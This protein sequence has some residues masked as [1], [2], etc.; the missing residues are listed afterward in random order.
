MKDTDL[1]II[2]QI[3]PPGSHIGILGGGQL[4]RMIAAAAV[5]MG[6]HIVI[7]SD[8][9]NAPASECATHT[10]HADY[11]D[12]TALRKFA[13][14]VDVVTLEF[15]NIPLESLNILSDI[16]PTRP[17]S[18]VLGIAQY[19]VAEKTF[20]DKH[21]IPTA[22]WRQ[23]KNPAELDLVRK[24]RPE[25][26]LKMARF[27]YDG[28]GQY[29]LNQASPTP[30][31]N[32]DAIYEDIINF[33]KEISVIIARNGKGDS[34]YYPPVHN[35]HRD[36]ILSSTLAP[37]HI[38]DSAKDKA[39]KIAQNIAE[40]IH[41]HGILAV[42]MFL[43]DDETIYV[44]EMAPRPHNSG[45]WSMDGATIC[46]FELLIRAICNLPLPMPQL[47]HPSVRMEN[48]LGDDVDRWQ[49]YLQDDSATLYLYGKG[50]ARAK[51]KMG[52]V[53]FIK[54]T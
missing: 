52:H 21:H 45:H 9:P 14:M 54:R 44:N 3:I 17:N 36:H 4:G 6:Y 48:L 32:K 37:A 19:R 11:T 47:L 40:A 13:E 18:H 15:E 5:R 29:R 43:C 23:V 31:F 49:E 42:E 8:V 46:Q 39:V 33:E 16:V 53:N 41:L 30:D 20:L 2:P 38:S 51:R 26:I 10:I 34:V 50:D 1:K 27:G 25:A 35:V 24:A 12:K 22:R 28:K 7:Y